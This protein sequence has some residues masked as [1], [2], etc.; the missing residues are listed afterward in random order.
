MGDDATLR[1]G[2]TPQE[3]AVFKA[4]NCCAGC[5]APD[6][7]AALTA[8]P[9]CNK[10]FCD[11]E[12]D[13]GNEFMP[14]PECTLRRCASCR[15]PIACLNCKTEKCD[16]CTGILAHCSKPSCAQRVHV[17]ESKSNR[18]P[19]VQNLLLSCT[20]CKS[21]KPG[22]SLVS[23]YRC[24]R[25]FCNGEYDEGKPKE[26]ASEAQCYITFCGHCHMQLGCYDCC[27]EKLMMG[28]KPTAQT[29]CV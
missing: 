12:D 1:G 10:K 24:A 20:R 27:R 4:T 18:I 23:C 19:L 5:A 25:M 15:D 26:T 6:I 9:I 14:V 21:G 16:A 22:D 17:I 11:N 13:N 7:Q 2:K 3:Y 8:C 29:M 28:A